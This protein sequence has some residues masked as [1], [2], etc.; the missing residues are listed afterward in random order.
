MVFK[1]LEITALI[2]GALTAA[3]YLVKSPV[4]DEVAAPAAPAGIATKVVS[5]L[6]LACLFLGGCRSVPANVASASTGV[7]GSYSPDSGAYGGALTETITF[8][9]PK[10]LA[11]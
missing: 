7:S 2:A 4:P 6:A 9:D 3:A 1:K 8:R 11:K 5:V 10:G